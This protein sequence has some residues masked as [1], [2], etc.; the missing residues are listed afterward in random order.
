[1]IRLIDEK[2]CKFQGLSSISPNMLDNREFL[3]Q[4][5]LYV[6]KIKRKLISISI[7]DGLGYCTRIE[8]GSLKI[9]HGALIIVKGLIMCNLYILDVSI[10][11]GHAYI[12]SQ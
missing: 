12:V 2:V 6:A 5:M 9:S 8:L 11:T 3:L 7:F 4:S 10:V 1:M